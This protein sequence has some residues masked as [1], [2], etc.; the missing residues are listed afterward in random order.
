MRALRARRIDV[1]TTE[2]NEAAT[3]NT[4]SY[5]L[6]VVE[7]IWHSARPLAGT[8]GQRYL[9]ARGLGMEHQRLRFLARCTY[10]PVKNPTRTGPAI[11]VPL[12][13]EDRLVGLQRI[14]LDPNDRGHY[15]RFKPVLCSERR[16]KMQLVPAGRVHALTE[17]AEDA[18]AYT[19]KHR[20]PAWGLPGIEWLAHTTIPDDV[21]ELIIAFD[22]GKP[23]FKAFGLLL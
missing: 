20:V 7:R 3:G 15:R 4:A 1:G 18:I 16:A 2:P 13:H 12:H 14:F 11:I 22:R 10:G 21:E 5:S 9:I 8:L 19:R 17:G 6:S 23:A